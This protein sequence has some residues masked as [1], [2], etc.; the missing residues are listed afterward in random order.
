MEM[1][2]NRYPLTVINRGKPSRRRGMRQ[3]QSCSLEMLKNQYPR[4][5]IRIYGPGN[6][7]STLWGEYLKCTCCITPKSGA[8]Y[9]VWH[10]TIFRWYQSG[11]RWVQLSV[12]HITR[13]FTDMLRSMS[14]CVS[15][16]SLLA[17]SVERLSLTNKYI[18]TRC[19]WVSHFFF[20]GC[21]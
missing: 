14:S 18:L 8:P 2:K 11:R 15:I 4:G 12:G 20:V 6:R 10:V 3:D 5:I 13:H 9:A 1:H 21:N 7:D 17:S 16:K 19:Q